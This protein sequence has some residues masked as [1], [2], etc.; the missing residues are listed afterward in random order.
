MAYVVIA[1]AFAFS[2]GIVAKA[3]GNS[4]W[5]WFVISGLL[6]FLGLLGAILYRS[7]RNELRRRCPRCGRVVKIHDALC[8]RCG[9]ELEFPEVTIAPESAGLNRHR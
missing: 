5:L 6:P 2:G 7:E 1:V 8:T 9:Q 3:K 4:F